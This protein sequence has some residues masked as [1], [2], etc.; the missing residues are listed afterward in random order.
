MQAFLERL[1]VEEDTILKLVENLNEGR[2]EE[3]FEHC[4]SDY[5]K[6]KE[7]WSQKEMFWNQEKM[8]WNQEKMSLNQEKIS[9]N[10]EKI[11]LNQEKTRLKQ[12]LQKSLTLLFSQKFQ[13]PSNHIMFFLK[14]CDEEILSQLIDEESSF[15]NVDDLKNYI[16]K[17][18]SKL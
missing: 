10:Q 4:M 7:M 16:E 15:K 11:S 18:N 9:L 12:K 2:H 13:V 6:E 3:M 17:N 5:R 1:G 8:F 14:E